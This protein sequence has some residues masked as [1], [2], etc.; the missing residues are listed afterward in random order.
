MY[1]VAVVGATGAVGRELMQ[2]LKDLAFPVKKLLPL[3]SERSAGTK[4]DTPFGVVEVEKLAADKFEG[5]D[6]AFF[7]AGATISKEYAQEAVKRGALVVDNSSAFR[8]DPNVPL[9]VPEVNMHAARKHNGIIANPNCSTIIMLVP[10]APIHE[11]YKIKRIIVSTYQAVS[12]AGHYGMEALEVETKD[13]LEGK[14]VV[15]TTLPVKSGAKHHQ[16]AFNVIPQVDVAMPDGY[17]KEEHKMI[18]E[19]RKI[20]EDDTMGICATTV[21][22]PVFRSH[23]ESITIETEIPVP[24][25]ELREVLANAPGVVLQ[26]DVDDFVYPMPYYVSGTDEVYVGRLREDPSAPN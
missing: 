3:A 5:I 8:M 7:C 22:V 24:L 6:V 19:T 2:V 4:M 12:G 15:P 20:F 16:I 10:L 21:R 9:V 11:K 26:D 17:T 25:Q 13:Y 1:N 23:S 18:L 14:T